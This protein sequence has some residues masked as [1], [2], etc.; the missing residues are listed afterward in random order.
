MAGLRSLLVKTEVTFSP[1]VKTG[2][3]GLEGEEWRR[4]KSDEQI[5]RGGSEAELYESEVRQGEE[6]KRVEADRGKIRSQ[7][8]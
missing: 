8:D 6:N 2:F 1:E 3:S 4:E 5:K 7:C